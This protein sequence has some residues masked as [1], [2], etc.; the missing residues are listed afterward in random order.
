MHVNLC[1]ECAIHYKGIHK[2]LGCPTC[3]A[4]I[5]DIRKTY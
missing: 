2:K 3:R 1:G 4:P 5:I